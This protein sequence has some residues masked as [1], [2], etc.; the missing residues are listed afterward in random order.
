MALDPP[1]P[2]M[3]LGPAHRESSG[4]GVVLHLPIFWLLFMVHFGAVTSRI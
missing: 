1:N 2:G 4:L 3:K